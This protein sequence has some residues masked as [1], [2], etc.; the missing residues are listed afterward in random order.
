M[1]AEITV[2]IDNV[3]GLPAPCSKDFHRWVA[4]ALQEHRSDSE[5]SIRIVDRVESQTLN[6]QYRGKNKPT[7]VLSFPTD[8]PAG[9]ELPLLG[10]LVICQPVVAEEAAEQHKLLSAHWAH[11]TIHGTLHLLGYDHLEDAEANL[12]EAMETK[13]LTTMG[14]PPPYETAN[15]DEDSL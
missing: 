8:F 11:L 9:V 12:M 5:V 13:I 10:D 3:D 2:D 15:G 6:C 1:S 7:N 4:A 14:Y